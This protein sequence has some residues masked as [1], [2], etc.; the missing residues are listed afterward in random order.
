MKAEKQREVLIY[1]LP[2]FSSIWLLLFLSKDNEAFPKYSLMTHVVT[3]LKV[4]KN[5]EKEMEKIYR[6]QDL[7]N[8]LITVLGKYELVLR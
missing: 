5:D 3:Q 2:L 4:S 8:T 6:N 7:S 1:E